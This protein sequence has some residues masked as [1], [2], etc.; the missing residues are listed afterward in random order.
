MSGTLY[1]LGV[2]PGDM[3]AVGF[4]WRSW[5]SGVGAQVTAA[6]SMER[7]NIIAL[8]WDWLPAGVVGSYR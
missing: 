2:G 8:D 5:M 1:G 7:R 3:G 4:L 6:G